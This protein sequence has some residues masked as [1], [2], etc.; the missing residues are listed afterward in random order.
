MAIRRRLKCQRHNGNILSDFIRDC[1]ENLNLY[2]P[3]GIIAMPQVSVERS[4][5]MFFV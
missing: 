4:K 3:A 2:T 5:D 1:H